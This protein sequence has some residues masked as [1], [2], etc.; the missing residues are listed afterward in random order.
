[1]SIQGVSPEQPQQKVGQ[2]AQSS[3]SLRKNGYTLAQWRRTG[4]LEL[5]FDRPL[6]WEMLVVSEADPAP[7]RLAIVVFAI[8]GG[9][10]VE[11]SARLH[12]GGLICFRVD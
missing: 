8:P 6:L 12:G 11:L 9:R 3:L 10:E 1:M 4:P 5:P 7:T 2:Q